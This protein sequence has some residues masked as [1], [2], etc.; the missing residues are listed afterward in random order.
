MLQHERSTLWDTAHSTSLPT[1]ET[2][3]AT[4]KTSRRKKKKKKKKTT[5]VYPT[6][7]SSSSDGCFIVTDHTRPQ[8]TKSTG[9]GRLTIRIDGN[10]SPRNSAG[11]RPGSISPRASDFSFG[12]I[13]DEDSR[14]L[15]QMTR[16]NNRSFVEEP[17]E[18]GQKGELNAQ[19]GGGR[20][21]SRRQNDEH[22]LSVADSEW[23]DI[24][25]DVD[26]GL[27][28][29]DLDINDRI[30]EHLEKSGKLGIQGMDLPVSELND[31]V[32][33]FS[34]TNKAATFQ[35]EG[36]NGDVELLHGGQEHVKMTGIHK[37]K[38]T[39]I[40]QNDY[41]DDLDLEDDDVDYGLEETN[42]YEDGSRG[43]SGPPRRDD[44]LRRRR[45]MK[46]KKSNVRRRASQNR[47]L[48][49][50]DGRGD[51]NSTE[52]G[53]T[54]AGSSGWRQPPGTIVVTQQQIIALKQN[55]NQAHQRRTKVLKK[56]LMAN[57]KF[58]EQL[59]KKLAETTEKLIEIQIR[60]H[61]GGAVGDEELTGMGKL[62][63]GLN[64]DAMS[65]VG[66]NKKKTAE[67]IKRDNVKRSLLAGLVEAA[68]QFRNDDM[69]V[70]ATAENTRR[71]CAKGCL[72]CCKWCND[73]LPLTHDVRSIE[74]RYGQNVASFFHFLRYVIFCFFLLSC[75][76]IATYSWHIT[77]ILH[78]SIQYNETTGIPLDL[79]RKSTWGWKMSKARALQGACIWNDNEQ[80]TICTLTYDEIENPLWDSQLDGWDWFKNLRYDSLKSVAALP[81]AFGFSTAADEQ[82]KSSFVFALNMVASTV[83]LA[84]LALIKLVRE[85][86]VFKVVHATDGGEANDFTR[87]SFDAW[88]HG[89]TN[90]L[91]AWDRKSAVTQQL[92]TTLHRAKITAEIN[93]RSR[94]ERCKI[95][96]NRLKGVIL[97][98]FVQSGG[99][100]LLYNLID[101]EN[102]QFKEFFQ[103][104][105]FI[106]NPQLA[107]LSVPLAISMLNATIP[108][109][110]WMI[111]V[112]TEKWDDK[113][114]EMK[115]ITLR[116]FIAK[117]LNV[118]IA[119]VSGALLWDPR[120]FKHTS[121]MGGSIESNQ[122]ALDK[123]SES[124][125]A[126]ATINEADHTSCVGSVESGFRDQLREKPLDGCVMDT[127]AS[128]LVQ[129]LIVNFIFGKVS[130]LL[131]TFL[132]YLNYIRK[133][134]KGKWKN[135]FWVPFYIVNLVY[136]VTLNVVC[137]PFYPLTFVIG[138]VLLYL[139]FKF[140]KFR[141]E[142]F[143]YKPLVPYSA[144]DIGLFFLRFYLVVV[145]FGVFWVHFFLS[146]ESFC[147]LLEFRSSSN[148][149]LNV[150][151]SSQ[152]IPKSTSEIYQRTQAHNLYVRAGLE[153]SCAGLS[154][155]WEPALHA[156]VLSH[157]NV[158]TEYCYDCQRTIE[159][160]EYLEEKRNHT[161]RNHTLTLPF[162]HAGLN[163]DPKDLVLQKCECTR[164][165][166]IWT[167][168]RMN[169]TKPLEI[170]LLEDSTWN[171][172][173]NLKPACG[174]F[175]G[176][177]I[178]YDALT[179]HMNEFGKQTF[180]TVIAEPSALTWLSIVIVGLCMS[181][182]FR[183]NTMKA[184][185]ITSEHEQLR[186][187]TECEG[188]RSR[189]NAIQQQLNLRRRQQ[190]AML[191]KE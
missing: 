34:T 126:L 113:K 163:S 90:Y 20:G 100:Y 42:R 177:R 179:N 61:A 125:D 161:K 46:R 8:R 152:R 49:G 172:E 51:G 41:Y 85:D 108:T 128:I 160:E 17:P 62:M 68:D 127:I 81:S 104:E 10:E 26:A 106:S 167:A 146:H 120:M 98:L 64:D 155:H 35:E 154:D 87:L 59:S 189:N 164:L 43:Q 129:L 135:E 83:V 185:E 112:K 134:K 78:A 123:I 151:I 50:A 94:W 73:H 150:D 66:K 153:N 176:Y 181:Y 3:N 175:V 142:M 24:L 121:Y 75:I 60:S 101:R 27:N 65:N 69:N 31:L 25:H 162:G 11:L 12:E 30:E 122:E 132:K 180:N 63:G 47:S 117:V 159:T 174:P 21:W 36:L 56:Q 139:E 22:G 82:S 15:A 80:H 97:S 141:L 191:K 5:Q 44:R 48:N 109:V 23:D 144:K 6:A 54:N 99:W 77:D 138:C 105:F 169:L 38:T 143:M 136:S 118:I 114:T 183:G 29:D 187:R 1:A 74:A 91:E 178:G 32:R 156:I 92:H 102:G 137:I 70:F 124:G 96:S 37:I 52:G 13:D 145:I 88:D 170:M 18:Y 184:S 111:V 147:Q 86:R 157:P 166:N 33:Q 103:S 45:K 165:S 149:T 76:N 39:R 53:S 9:P 79:Q 55:V 173:Y 89:I 19:F 72:I 84:L 40:D 28:D 4:A 133:G 171:W 2:T 93:G 107:N 148:T 110:I 7:S 67:A 95:W 71:G 158:T 186:L 140:T 190:A 131:Q 16:G 58:I 119:V 182:F 130:A 14:A 168:W 115:Q 57:K 188:L 116:V